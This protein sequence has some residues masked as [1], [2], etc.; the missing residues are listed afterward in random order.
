VIGG[1]RRSSGSEF[2][3]AARHYSRRAKAT[4]ALYDQRVN[5]EI[6]N[7]GQERPLVFDWFFR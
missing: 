6:K 5:K 4:L 3:G 2:M 1:A 7:G